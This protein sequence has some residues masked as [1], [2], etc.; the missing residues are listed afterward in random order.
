M[1]WAETKR[2]LVS[3]LAIGGRARTGLKS[4]AQLA[5]LTVFD[6]LS[7]DDCVVFGDRFRRRNHCPTRTGLSIGVTD[8]K[9]RSR[10]RVR[11]NR[12]IKTDGSCWRGE[13]GDHHLSRSLKF[14]VPVIA[15]LDELT[16]H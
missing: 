12:C 11:T 9:T 15:V 5:T 13:P 7:I 6:K 16:I 3:E 1:I 10:I 4:I 2:A 8:S 14:R